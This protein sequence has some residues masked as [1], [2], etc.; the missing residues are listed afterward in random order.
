LG[1]EF[2]PNFDTFGDLVDKVYEN[3]MIGQ[4]DLEVQAQHKVKEELQKSLGSSECFV[5]LLAACLIFRE[6]DFYRLNFGVMVETDNVGT[7]TRKW[8]KIDHGA[9]FRYPFCNPHDDGMAKYLPFSQRDELDYSDILNYYLNRGDIMD[10]GLSEELVDHSKLSEELSNMC[11]FLEESRELFENLIDKQVSD[12]E[13]ILCVEKYEGTWLTIGGK[14]F[15]YDIKKDKFIADDLAQLNEHFKKMLYSQVEKAKEFSEELSRKDKGP[16]EEDLNLDYNSLSNITE[17]SARGDSSKTHPEAA[18]VIESNDSNGEHKEAIIPS[19]GNE[20]QSNAGQ[21][22]VEWSENIHEA[23]KNSSDVK[24]IIQ[25][26]QYTMLLI[27]M[28]TGLRLI[29]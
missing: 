4:N 5:K 27:K 3:S 22:S 11:S 24:Q 14:N 21:N 16:K 19:M 2:V 7:E 6:Y 18:S 25:A 8:A 29:Q 9:S 23:T 26:V 13:K 10:N 17:S 15:S 1:S 28:M 20:E 12:L